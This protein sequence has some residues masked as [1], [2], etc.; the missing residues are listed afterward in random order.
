[1]ANLVAAPTLRA[2]RAHARVAAT[3]LASIRC[4]EDGTDVIGSRKVDIVTGLPQGSERRIRF[5]PGVVPMTPPPSGFWGERFTAFPVF[6][7]PRLRAASDG[8]PHIDIDKV[9]DFLLADAS[10]D[11]GRTGG[12]RCLI[13]H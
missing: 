3:A 4:T 10:H 11:D 2:E 7:P 8:I 1:M 13:R 6:Q 9:I 5:F 12:R